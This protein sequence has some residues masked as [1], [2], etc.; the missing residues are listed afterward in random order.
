MLKTAT[1][2]KPSPLVIEAHDKNV[3]LH[4]ALRKY[5][6]D[7]RLT[8]ASQVDAALTLFLDKV[9]KDWRKDIKRAQ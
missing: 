9:W 4:K 7:R 8:F 1:D 3:L 2:K 6:E 5:C